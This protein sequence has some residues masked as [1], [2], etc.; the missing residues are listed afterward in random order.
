MAVHEN[1]LKAGNPETPVETL[2]SLILDADASV[3]RRLAE[4]PRT[5]E[6]L[7]M[8]LSRDENPDVRCAVA[9]NETAPRV[10][11]DELSKDEC[12][13]VRYALA[14]HYTLPIDLL[15]NFAESDENPYVKD[16]ARRTLEGIFL[17][18]ALREAGFVPRAGET[19]KLGE[20]LK[21]SEVLTAEHVEEL[22]RIS[23]E[24]QIPLGHAVVE[25]RCVARSVVVAALKS[26]RAVRDGKLSH[27][28]AIWEI[29][30]TWGRH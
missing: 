25:S 8:Q 14:G 30:H 17:E 20:L 9:E 15:E 28:D 23:K 26:Q 27:E 10:V 16:H 1:Y 13:Q 19:D 24:R 6:D 18:Q 7:L 29:K 21:D 5:P 12:V 3:R 2:R 22:L 11:L 4:N